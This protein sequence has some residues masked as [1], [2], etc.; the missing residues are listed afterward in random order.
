MGTLS[1]TPDPAQGKT[2]LN[3][4]SLQQ[5]MSSTGARSRD[6]GSTEPGSDHMVAEGNTPF[7][8]LVVS[9]QEERVNLG[10]IQ[11]SLG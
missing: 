11:R 9:R 6:R 5:V 2:D 4:G 1:G 3:L 8:I 7:D 10:N